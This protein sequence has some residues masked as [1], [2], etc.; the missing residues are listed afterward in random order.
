MIAEDP[1][2]RVFARATPTDMRKSFDTL[3]ALVTQEMGRDPMSGDLYLFVN[4]GCRVAKV[5]FW[6]G[7][8]L[9]VLHKRI[10][11]GRFAAPWKRSVDGTI[12]MSRSEL[13]LFLEG[14]QLVFIGALSP[15]GSEH[16]KVATKALVVR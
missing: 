3:A 9:V 1:R 15:P 5:L 13:S 11:S 10:S 2:L 14:S 7:S 8:G 4:Q 6:D 16:G 12:R